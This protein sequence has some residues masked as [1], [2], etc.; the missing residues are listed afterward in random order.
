MHVSGTAILLLP[1]LLYYNFVRRQRWHEIG[2]HLAILYAGKTLYT[3]FCVTTA[4]VNVNHQSTSDPL[5]P[6]RPNVTWGF[7]LV[8]TL[9]VLK[10]NIG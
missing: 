7:C 9:L 1:L 3:L 2:W 10:C 5:E 8:I 6:Q 4:A